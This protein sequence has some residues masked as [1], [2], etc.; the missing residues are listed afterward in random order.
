MR[1]KMDRPEML[2]VPLAALDYIA[3][4]E[5][6]NAKLRKIMQE[7]VDDYAIGPIERTKIQAA[8]EAE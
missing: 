5:A 2:C 6:E 7:L 4:L 3:E 8:L 1:M